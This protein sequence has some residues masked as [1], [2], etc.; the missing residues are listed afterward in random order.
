MVTEAGLGEAERHG[1]LPDGKNERFSLTEV[2]SAALRRSRLA[3]AAAQHLPLSD[4]TTE[5]KRMSEGDTAFLARILKTRSKAP[6]PAIAQSLRTFLAK[7]HDDQSAMAL[8][9]GL[10]Y[11]VISTRHAAVL[12]DT[13][14]AALL[15]ADRDRLGFLVGHP[16]REVLTAP[17]EFGVSAA[18][19]TAVWSSLVS[20]PYVGGV[21]ALAWL[22]ADPPA[23]WN[24]RQVAAAA[25]AWAAVRKRY[26]MMPEQPVPIGQLCS[27]VAGME[28]S[29]S[30]EELAGRAADAHEEPDQAAPQEVGADRDPAPPN[31]GDLARRLSELAE[32][33]E[34]EQAVYAQVR[35]TD[36]PTI[37][38]AINAGLVPPPVE[39]ARLNGLMARMTV[40]FA[41]IADITGEPAPRTAADAAEHLQEMAEAIA[42]N[43]ALDRIRSLA[44]LVAPA[45][46]ATETESIRQLAAAADASTDPVVIAALDALVTAVQL[47]AS[48]PEQS[49]VL[50]RVVQS[51][52][53]SASVL[54]MLAAGG[55]VSLD[56]PGLLGTPGL[57]SP[58]AAGA[59]VDSSQTTADTAAHRHSDSPDTATDAT[60]EGAGGGDN[61][62]VSGELA[63]AVQI[64]AVD[65]A[66]T[67]AIDAG[68]RSASLDAPPDEAV[69]AT[70]AAESDLGEALAD[71]D[72]AIPTHPIAAE[73]PTAG[74]TLINV[75]PVDAD[76]DSSEKNDRESVA[77]DPCTLYADLARNQRFA[78]VGWLA[79]ALERPPAIS[80]AHR[81]AA[82]ASAM[83]GS[84]GPN[85][86]AFADEVKNLDADALAPL[87][88]IQMIVYAASARAGLLS[89]TAGAAGPLRDI[90]PSITKAGSAIEGLT[91][92]LLVAIY[93]GAYLTARSADGVAEATGL[94]ARHATLASTARNLLDTAGSRTIRYQ[95]ATELWKLWMEPKGYL[96]TA[97]AIV[98]AGSRGDDDL[99]FV[100]RRVTALRSRNA[101]E[102]A[103]DED[104]PKV[105][106]G[107]RNKRIEAR[108]RD[109]IIN[110]TGDVADV[111]GDWVANVD[112]LGRA[113]AGG[114][115]MAAQ[116]NELR[117]R[118]ATVRDDALAEL[119]ALATSDN[120][121][122]NAA[123]EAGIALLA[124]TLD[125]V[126]GEAAVDAGTET[127]ADRV[128]NGHLVFA[129]GLPVKTAPAL[130]PGRGVT[131]TDIASAAAA[132]TD[133]PAG[134]TAA[135]NRRRDVH[136]HVGT[137][138]VLE[139]L[140]GWD[141]G[142]ARRL[143]AARER[144]V[145]AAVSAVDDEVTALSSRID[146]DRRF[147]QLGYDQWSDLSTRARAY[148][149]ENRG[150]RWDFDVMESALLDVESSREELSLAAVEAAWERMGS[151]EL[152]DEQITR[153]SDRI[154]CGDL[155]TADEYL[156]TI[157]AD[158]EL[159]KV[160]NDADHLRQFFPA[161][162]ALFSAVGRAGSPL[163]DLRQ[164]I[165][166]GE[167]PAEGKLSDALDFAEID[168]SAI[169]RN[170]TAADRVDQWLKLAGGRTLDGRA[171]HVKP[172]LEQLGFIVA[173]TRI[174][175]NRSGR[176]PGGRSA[177]MHLSGV[178]VTS[179][180]ALIPAFGTGMSPSGDTLRLLAVWGTPTVA[181]IVEQLRSEPV[182]HSVIVL[183]FGTLGVSARNDLA[184]ALRGGRKLPPTIVID[185][186]MFAYLAAQATPRRDIT[187][188]VALPFASAE[189]FTPNVA[190]LVPVE[191]F[192]GRTEELD[193][194]VNRMGSC[195]VYGGRQLG[196]SALLRAAAREFDNSATRHAIYQ[197]I[198][199]VGQAIP[200][201][202]VW[203]TL[204]PR[205]AER[206]VVPHDM[207]SADV[208]SAVGRH[209]KEWIAE[210]SDR[211][212]LLLL[213][214]SDF[215]LDADAKDGSFPHVTR[216]K[217]LMEE[218]GRAV[219]V[220]FAGLHQTA[221][222]ERLSNH[223]LA[224][225]GSP[226]CVGP[227]TPQYA[228]DLLTRPLDALGYRFADQNEA[229]RVLAL[230]NNQPALIQLFGAQLL[231]RLQKAPPA[232]NTPPRAVTAADIEAI[233]ADEALRTEFRRR[234]E[235]TLNLD[236][237]Y[238]IIAYSVAFHAHEHGIDSALSP[239]DLRSQ[240]EQWWPQG[241]AAKDVLT[242]EFRALLDE[243]VA[244]GVLSYNSDGAY[245]LRTPNVLALL[246]SRD[247]VDDV[248]DQAEAQQPP[249]SFDGSLL[250]PAF[251]TGETRSPLTSAQI[252]DL[253]GPDS[254]VR[255]VVG[256]PA[257]TA[258]RCASVLSDRNERAAYGNVSIASKT[259]TAA[260]LLTACEQVAALS[261]QDIA[262]V[263]VDLK[264]TSHEAAVAAW[265]QAREQI[266][267][268]SAGTLC[269]ILL[270]S[271]AQ[272]AM[273]A[274]C[275][276]D[277][278]RSSGLTELH[279]YDSVG[280]RLWLT[281]TTLPFQDEA[282]RA[283]LLQA[284]GGW[285][286]LVNRVVANLR[287]HDRVTTADPLESIRCWLAEPA[288]ADTFVEACGLRADEVLS[289]AWSFLVTEFG[290]D[291]ADPVTL[292]ELLSLATDDSPALTDDAL[293][294]TGY[295][296]PSGVVEVLR[297]LGVLVPSSE[298][299]LLLEPVAAAATLTAAG[300]DVAGN[301]TV[302][303]E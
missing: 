288:N 185:D 80:A 11:G 257:L 169:V 271:P 260:G 26:P 20:L 220:V 187:M 203:P 229:A 69:S 134:W 78:L 142:L 295:G 34:A 57:E 200:A 217:E 150:R 92:A 18:V 212:L 131:V 167:N 218:T 56:A 174:P 93:S 59:D 179:G 19:R 16:L 115:W 116:I 5:I 238:K 62:A 258:E 184:V 86:A 292:A 157:R 266:A 37:V 119:E 135:F 110:W 139:M 231:R 14:L 6:A 291:A 95:A 243:C 22:V 114:G 244:L 105:M 216:F 154:A 123:I 66:D 210:E 197:S 96:G 276:R 42:T 175:P 207:P 109:K 74:K 195:I 302:E 140:R 286:I 144:D 273:W 191:M 287:D 58:S 90:T 155:T 298:G 81:L 225:L 254:R 194:V 124:D 126:S 189:P 146:S 293:A 51:T 3:K 53:P 188:S 145:A 236:P 128:A 233:W 234:F 270:T 299:Q 13:E 127:P 214:E 71:L 294:L 196:K 221:R 240:C 108:A 100:R 60:T 277:A 106:P 98:A 248:L 202:A 50:S 99:G 118:V 147:G 297:M 113:S 149:A 73:M 261:A 290:S 29:G 12:K 63:G 296:K 219:K 275:N 33:V 237:R 215:F 2:E 228:Y 54:V 156:E 107:R 205:L 178:R 79:E 101:I 28:L 211:Q 31:E 72:F 274:R 206:G 300:G 129:D 43:S 7:A 52:L 35:D 192:Y 269:I 120:D 263:L 70:I 268:Y 301:M 253:L 84:A 15:S 173:E 82:H 176:S 284:T 125:L 136:D 282:S 262:L 67:D 278:D 230:A 10:H 164:A 24:D 283:D 267:G 161:F 280:L 48:D 4:I 91:E 255:V 241:F 132:I 193:Q 303:A 36:L 177:W 264:G 153:V 8:H 180:N 160:H 45:Y 44:G 38:S 227:L 163:K 186:P 40:L 204:W 285:P 23:T 281:E 252:S 148:D 208:A 198:Y 166:N 85:A 89:P 251:G 152:T 9:D 47:G 104:S 279:R 201:D 87:T 250:R 141:P 137:Y 256:S 265:E 168:L 102:K 143:S 65:G 235:W 165:A 199:K 223:P 226:V 171:G 151:R 32:R 75:E 21:A 68:T 181:E 39:L 112:H 159:P 122:R 55:H 289:A 77:I 222:F 138:V 172:I 130:L 272:A 61:R 162:P 190:G 64:G 249:E 25:N 245:R 242:S 30:L 259:T 49:A 209:I 170:R 46:V 83:R 41:E 224:H 1:C 117:A 182:E 88:G 183:Y 158:G 94:E 17:E 213:D 247:E 239:T 133:G 232:P 97:L 121:A 246:G 111:L 103:I 27:T 76:A